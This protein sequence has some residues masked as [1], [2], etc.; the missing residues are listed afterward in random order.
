MRLLLANVDVWVPAHFPHLKDSAV[1]AVVVRIYA[2][3]IVGFA[4]CLHV[5][6]V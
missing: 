4:A 2:V 6:Y 3:F 5:A 1:N